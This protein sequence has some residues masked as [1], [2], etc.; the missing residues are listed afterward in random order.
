MRV[1]VDNCNP[2]SQ[3]LISLIFC[4]LSFEGTE[5]L[6]DKQIVGLI[7][8]YNMEGSRYKSLSNKSSLLRM[9]CPDWTG[10]DIMC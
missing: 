6:A 3:S 8:V 2:I 4:Q 10:L 1:S 9:T 5:C 7:D